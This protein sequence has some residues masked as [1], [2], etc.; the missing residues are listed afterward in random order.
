MYPSFR[1]PWDSTIDNPGK[2]KCMMSVLP[3]EPLNHVTQPAI[4]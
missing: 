3:D 1:F 4:F 2:M